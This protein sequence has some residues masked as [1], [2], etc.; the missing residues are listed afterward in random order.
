MPLKL[1]VASDREYPQPNQYLDKQIYEINQNKSKRLRDVPYNI[2]EHELVFDSQLNPLHQMFD[3]SIASYFD[4]LRSTRNCNKVIQQSADEQSNQEIK[5]MVELE[6]CYRMSGI[7]FFPLV[8]PASLRLHKN[9]VDSQVL[10]NE[11]L[12]I[13]IEVFEETKLRYAPPYY[14]LLKKHL[15]SGDRWILFKHTMPKIVN[16]NHLWSTT[17]Q[18]IITTDKQIYIFAKRCYLELVHIHYRTQ[19]ISTLDN[20]LFTDIALDQNAI[21]LSFKVVGT[22]EIIPITLQMHKTSIIHCTV[23]SQK[24]EKWSN[25]LLGNLQDLQNKLQAL[26][27]SI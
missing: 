3:S 17:Y 27:A 6:N 8:A 18:G 15:K 26:K 14:I 7:T 5:R 21:Y 23:H 1:T 12:G 2:S 10:V 22:N 9:S 25:I 16:A 24:Y 4:T 19:Y 20:E 11:M 13:R